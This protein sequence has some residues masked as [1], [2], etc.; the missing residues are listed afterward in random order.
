LLSVDV[1]KKVVTSQKFNVFTK[2]DDLAV[3]TETTLSKI[4]DVTTL[5]QPTKIIDFG[6]V[7]LFK[8]YNNSLL[9]TVLDNWLVLAFNGRYVHNVD[10]VDPNTKDIYKL[11]T[12]T[13]IILFY[14]L[15]FNR[16]GTTDPVMGDVRYRN[17][18][19]Q[20]VTRLHYY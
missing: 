2:E 6:K 15:L 16:L 17:F 7:T 13:G 11:N 10:F 19:N 4:G 9:E 12:T 14:Y 18:L 20:H 3:L 5:T 1:I 8:S